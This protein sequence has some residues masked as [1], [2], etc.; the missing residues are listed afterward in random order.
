MLPV[1]SNKYLI[2][3][4]VNVRSPRA[5]VQECVRVRVDAR[6]LGIVF[7]AFSLNYPA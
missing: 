6:G 4:C 1:K 5:C 3:F 2:F 7:C